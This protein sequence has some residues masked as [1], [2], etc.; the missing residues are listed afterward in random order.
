M[1]DAH[2]DDRI[3]FILED[4]ASRVLIVS[5]GTVERAEGLVDEDVV[6]LNISDVLREDIGILS[7]LPV[8][9]GDVACLLYT[10]GTTGLPKGVRVT[11]KSILNLSACY[12]DV[13]GL[14]GSD[15]D[16]NCFREVKL[17]E[18]YKDG[19]KGEI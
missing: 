17:L 5:D 3:Q 11:R 14:G 19:M 15:E 9:C 8:V 6:V 10:S 4:S 18:I 13:Y 2:P 16:L 1:D 12:S 7:R